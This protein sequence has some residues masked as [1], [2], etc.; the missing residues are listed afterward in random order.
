MKIDIVCKKHPKYKGKRVPTTFCDACW[1]LCYLL[2]KGRLFGFLAGK[3]GVKLM[4][5]QDEPAMLK[6]KD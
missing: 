5:I 4:A 1:I 6:R 2:D 3:V